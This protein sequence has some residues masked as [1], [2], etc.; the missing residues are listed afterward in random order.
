M[1]LFEELARDSRT[2]RESLR[3]APGFTVGVVMTLALGIA[4]AAAALSVADRV[5]RKPLPV[6]DEHQ[7]L[8][9][10]GDN[11]NKSPA[12]LPLW[13]SEYQAFARSTRVFSSV[14]G[15]DYNGAWPRAL[16]IGDTTNS[17]VSVMVT[18]NFFETLGIDPVAG[19]L[20]RVDDD[21]P[22]SGGVVVISEGY[23]RR[24]FGGDPAAIGKRIRIDAFDATIVGVVPAAFRFP[25]NTEVWLP[26]GQFSRAY[27]TPD[28]DSLRAYVDMVGRLR[29]NAS[30][31]AAR[32]ELGAFFKF[33]GART[34]A[35]KEFALTLDPAVTPLRRLIVGDVDGPLVVVSIAAV[36]LLI[37]TFVS[38]AGLLLVRALMRARE[39]AIR[40]ALG[41]GRGRLA[42]QVLVEAMLLGAA[43]VVIGLSL[44]RAAI[45]LFV[46]IAPV[47]IPLVDVI[48]LDPTIGAIVA[49]ASLFALAGFALLPLMRRDANASLLRERSSTGDRRASLLRESLV[50]LQIAVAVCGLMTAGIALTSFRN[51]LHLDLGFRAD[52]VAFFQLSAR[53][54]VKLD[55]NTALSSV[56]RIAAAARATPGVVAASPVLVKPFAGPGGW[57]FSYRLPDDGPGDAANR[58]MLNVVPAGPEYFQ[59]VGTR[60]IAGR[61]FTDD[62]RAG[63]DPVVIVDASLAKQLWPGKDPL[64]QRIA[65][66]AGSGVMQRVVGVAEDTRY[67]EFLS[68]RPTVYAPFRQLS[69]F[70]PTYVAVRT[71]TNPSDLL[72]TLQG[73]IASTDPVWS[74]MSATTFDREVAAPLATPRLN[75]F[76]L[77]TF[78]LSIVILAT[79]GVYGLVA[80]YVRT[81]RLDIAIR[82][83]L[84]AGTVTVHRLVL[85]RAAVMSA[86]GGVSGGLMVLLGAG[87]L[88]RV[89]F[90]VSPTD[91]L[92]LAG[93]ITLPVAVSLIACVIPARRAAATNPVEALRQSS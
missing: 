7:V 78:A 81:R 89:V 27:G 1:K 92:T 47:D 20:L 38:A 5:L 29:P 91:P 74:V 2:A 8:V 79:V 83:A 88:R 39:L 86:I 48:S 24:Q 35:L 3:R 84:G 50:A 57:D 64:G 22:G 42:R 34:A 77:A 30:E 32:A 28:A 76:L 37:V 67:R 80:A 12:H 69:K 61:S 62:D 16:W 26:I 66:T 46:S 4:T 75:S 36:L 25:S 68:P 90:G 60:V 55:F 41:A 52:N 9:M 6:H 18:G 43:A 56:E 14:A 21:L 11:R 15:V 31:G 51:L 72:R 82:L 65:V 71:R 93:A 19:R 73:V 49:G 59:T 63:A 87:L 23:W 33:D 58:Q 17:A 45:R 54:G 10:W 40:A 53:P 44:A 13:G 70:P 85:R